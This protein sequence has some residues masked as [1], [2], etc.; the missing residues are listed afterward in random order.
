MII[1]H[2]IAPCLSSSA[3]SLSCIKSYSRTSLTER[4]QAA[5]CQ[6]PRFVAVHMVKDEEIATSEN[7][8]RSGSVA[9]ALYAGG[10]GVAYCSQLVAAR[11]MGATSFGVYAYVLAWI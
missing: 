8:V 1:A 11:F 5:A 2:W 9:F 6:Q 7:I 4:L 10:A 3:K